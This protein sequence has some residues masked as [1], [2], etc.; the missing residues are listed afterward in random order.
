MNKKPYLLD[1]VFALSAAAMPY[2]LFSSDL[3]YGHAIATT[4]I[5][6]Y[7]NLSL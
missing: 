4:M 3:G 2:Y 1:E 7:L 5:R 6:S